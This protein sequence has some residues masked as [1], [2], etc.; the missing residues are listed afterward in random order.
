MD[1]ISVLQAKIARHIGEEETLM[2]KIQ[3]AKAI[4]AKQLD[5]GRSK[6]GTPGVFLLKIMCN[7]YYTVEEVI[8]LFGS[9]EAIAEKAIKQEGEGKLTH[10][11][12]TDNF[13]ADLVYLEITGDVE[14]FFRE[15]TCI[16]KDKHNIV[17]LLKDWKPPVL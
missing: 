6:P 8:S 12:M 13:V 7:D 14:D 15:I 16:F 9:T 4:E 10:V 17:F 3:I 11:L 1:T 5:A 2:K